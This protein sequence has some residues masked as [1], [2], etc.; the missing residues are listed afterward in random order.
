[1]VVVFENNTASSFDYTTLV[2]GQP[3]GF[4][5]EAYLYCECQLAKL[6]VSQKVAT[7][8]RHRGDVGVKEV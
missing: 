1:M 6:S 5:M 4:S 2:L 3:G 7:G 8:Q